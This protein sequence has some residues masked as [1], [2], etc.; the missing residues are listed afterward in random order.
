MIGLSLLRHQRGAV[1]RRGLAASLDAHL[2][3]LRVISDCH[4][5]V[6]LDHFIP[7]FLSYLSSCFSKVTFGHLPQVETC[8]ARRNMWV[9]GE[10][11]GRRRRGSSVIRRFHLLFL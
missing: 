5:A 2:G 7:G 3:W 9:R 8:A 11:P 1:P 10:Y 6:Q 4:F